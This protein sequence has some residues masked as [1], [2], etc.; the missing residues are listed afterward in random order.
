MQI[1]YKLGL[2]DGKKSSHHTFK[3]IKDYF[4]CIGRIQITLKLSISCYG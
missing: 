4:E 3:Q 1:E 2:F